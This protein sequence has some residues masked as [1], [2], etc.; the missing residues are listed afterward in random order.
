MTA[1]IIA[2]PSQNVNPYPFGSIDNCPHFNYTQDVSVSNKED[3]M[4]R[5]PYPKG[6]TQIYVWGLIIGFVLIGLIRS[7][8]VT[9]DNRVIAHAEEASKEEIRFWENR[10]VTLQQGHQRAVELA[11]QTNEW[12]FRQAQ[13]AVANKR[14][15]Q[16][17]IK[18]IGERLAC[19]DRNA[20]E[21]NTS[22]AETFASDL[23]TLFLD[24]TSSVVQRSIVY[25]RLLQPKLYGDQITKHFFKEGAVT[26][27]ALEQFVAQARGTRRLDPIPD[28][29]KADVVLPAEPVYPERPSKAAPDVSW[30]YTYDQYKLD[31]LPFWWLCSTVLAFLFTLGVNT[32][33]EEKAVFQLTRFV[34]REAE[35]SDRIWYGV[36]Q[37]LY[38]PV[39]VLANLLKWLWIFV[40]E[41]VLLP[42]ILFRTPRHMMYSWKQIMRMQSIRSHL[43]YNRIR[44]L[45]SLFEKATKQ[46]SDVP[47]DDPTRKEMETSLDRLKRTIKELEEA[48]TPIDFTAVDARERLER[49]A[50]LRS[51]IDA[52]TNEAI[53]DLRAQHEVET[54]RHP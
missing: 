46:L 53:S 45:Q 39:I 5:N 29:V 47:T 4:D 41:L 2:Q 28:P 48:Y 19:R 52:A 6:W 44:E 25:K 21:K 22:P 51:H 35:T 30:L 36:L 10:L 20:C 38:L 50:M 34:S 12:K 23:Y 9:A 3:E 31:G 54:V 37:I 33:T 1:A 32:I 7:C 26:S 43:H 42:L 11:I 14:Q 15:H 27:E 24:D 40:H 17:L 16:E 13:E 18:Q 8:C 49:L